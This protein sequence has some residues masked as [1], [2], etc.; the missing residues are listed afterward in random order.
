MLTCVC[1]CIPALTPSHW[2]VTFSCALCPS[3]PCPSTTEPSPYP[4]PCP[5]AGN[6]VPVSMP[7]AFFI[8]QVGLKGGIGNFV[9]ATRP[10][11]WMDRNEVGVLSEGVLKLSEPLNPSISSR[12]NHLRPIHSPTALCYAVRLILI[13]SLTMLHIYLSTCT[14][15]LM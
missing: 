2:L 11:V 10:Y 12:L 13:Y 1:K 15:D 8:T 7:H 5:P 3:Q 9:K 14:A 6:L 4:Q